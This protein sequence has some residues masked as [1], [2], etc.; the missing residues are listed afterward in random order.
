MAFTQTILT[1]RETEYDTARHI[2]G[3]A[4]AHSAIMA[5]SV[6]AVSAISEDY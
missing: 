6:A 1:L 5:T 3:G 4:L 2:W